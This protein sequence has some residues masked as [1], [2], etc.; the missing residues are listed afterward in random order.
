MAN[1][2]QSLIG[3]LAAVPLMAAPLLSQSTAPS[4]RVPDTIDTMARI[5]APSAQPSLAA[6]PLA[7]SP[8]AP[9]A[10]APSAL[11][12]SPSPS[13]VA[14]AAASP[15]PASPALKNGHDLSIYYT[16]NIIGEVD[17]CG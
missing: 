15:S 1:R 16:S 11:T 17:P 6:S 14:S 10:S 13:S 3:I 12:P 8:A 5:V 4:P 2:I 9:S 7:P